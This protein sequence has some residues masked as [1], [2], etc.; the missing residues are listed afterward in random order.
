[1]IWEPPGRRNSG[2]Q[3]VEVKMYEKRVKQIYNRLTSL[4]RDPLRTF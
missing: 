4:K 1:M 2:K 3:F